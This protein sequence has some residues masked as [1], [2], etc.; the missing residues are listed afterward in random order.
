MQNTTAIISEK[1]SFHCEMLVIGS[2]AY[3]GG[4]PGSVRGVSSIV[5]SAISINSNSNIRLTSLVGS[6]T[7]WLNGPGVWKGGFGKGGG[8]V[9]RPVD[10]FIVV[11][12]N[13]SNPLLWVVESVKKG[14][15]LMADVMVDVRPTHTSGWRGLCEHMPDQRVWE[16]MGVCRCVHLGG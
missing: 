9:V 10:T 13:R 16:S 8:R 7:V 15:V 11:V 6:D 5:M 3:A 2:R 1:R 4:Q 12:V 14:S